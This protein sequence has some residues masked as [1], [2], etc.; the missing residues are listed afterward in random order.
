EIAR[1]ADIRYIGQ[2]SE[3]VVSLPAGPYSDCSRVALIAAFER[4]YL[5]AFTRTPP[6]T[7]VELINV[8]VSA[9]IPLEGRG[10]PLQ[11]PSP[12][13]ARSSPLTGSRPVYLPEARGFRAVSIYARDA[14]VGGQSFAGPAIVEEP[15]STLLVGPDA[16]LEVLAS[17]S[18]L[19][20]L[21]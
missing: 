21:A 6:G 4:A 7:Q 13:V 19:V 18:I 15:D 10:V 12:A 2:A 20:N 9:S 17:G 5:A 14:L 8:R 3:L 1:F 16:R 11:Q